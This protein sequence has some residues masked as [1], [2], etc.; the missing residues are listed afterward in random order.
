MIFLKKI[1]ISTLSTVFFSV[2][3]AFIEYTPVAGQFPNVGYSSFGGL[4]VIYCVYSFP[5]FLIGGSLYSYFVDIYFD[6]I[7]FPSK[8]QKYIFGLF[9]Y[10]VGGLLIVGILLIVILLIYGNTSGVLTFKFFIIGIIA[11]LLFYHT[12]L[13]LDKLRFV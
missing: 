12:S 13:V 7:H 5:L 9:I 6:N 1:L 2:S 4:F 3:L 11:S 10:I 8:L